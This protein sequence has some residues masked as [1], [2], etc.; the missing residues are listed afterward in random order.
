MMLDRINLKSA[1]IDYTTENGERKL[2]VEALRQGISLAS[3]G[4]KK[5]INW[6]FSDEKYIGSFLWI[7]SD[8]CLGLRIK[9]EVR[10]LIYNELER[11]KLYFRL[12]A[13]KNRHTGYF[14]IK[15]V[16]KLR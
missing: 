12:R 11:K 13:A 4:D 10:F 3:T 6:V 16:K 2:W 15:V 1:D 9:D 8:N 5:T 14:F 7:I